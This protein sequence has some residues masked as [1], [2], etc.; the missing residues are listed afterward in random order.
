MHVYF[1]HVC[2]CT[3]FVIGARGGQKIHSDWSYRWL[4]ELPHGF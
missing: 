2:L 1:L 4:C 3:T